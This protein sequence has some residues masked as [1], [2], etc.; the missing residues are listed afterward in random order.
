SRGAISE[1]RRASNVD[2][3][4]KLPGSWH[5][6]RMDRR[7]HTID[8]AVATTLNLIAAKVLA[9]RRELREVAR[10]GNDQAARESQRAWRE[11][12]G[13]TPLE[14]AQFRCWKERSAR[15]AELLERAIAED[16]VTV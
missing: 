6:V 1:A 11:H 16:R 12:E 3:K 10:S 13:S 5:K 14:V 8:A 15:A 7:H 2:E 9:E 4:I